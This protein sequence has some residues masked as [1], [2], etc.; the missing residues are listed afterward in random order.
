MSTNSPQ[1]HHGTGVAFALAQLGAHATAQF[2]RRMADLGLTPAQ[3][4]L[5]RLLAATPG[6]SQKELADD[7][8]MPPTRFVPFADELDERG[9]IERRKNPAD[10]R[11]HAV[12]LTEA[13]TALLGEIAR[14]AMAHEQEICTGLSPG[15]REQ[16]L[17]LLMRISD[18]QKLTAGIHPGYRHA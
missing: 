6:R 9:L 4:G 12:Y 7:L 11:L 13:G 10:R 18:Q 2:A 14:A 8:G 16:L 15:E 3:A 1:R 17:D 5:L